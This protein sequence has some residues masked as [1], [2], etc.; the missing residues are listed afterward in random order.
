MQL[1]EPVRT[2]LIADDH[3]LVRAGLVAAV[4]HALAPERL[5]EAEDFPETLEQATT[6]E[7]L[8]LIVL[9]LRMPGAQGLS[10]LMMLK[11]MRPEAPVLVCSGVAEKRVIAAASAVGA[12][13]FVSKSAS[14]DEIEATLI[15]VMNGEAPGLPAPE[16]SAE[17]KDFA[18]R[19]RELSPQQFRVMS[20][21]GDGLLNKQIAHEMGLSVSTVKGHV[22]ELLRKLN[23]PRR[24]MLIAALRD[25]SLDE[26]EFQL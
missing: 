2:V 6:A 20:L 8:D 16:A 25:F 11:A 18:A 23:I 4:A 19:I 3:P 13:G 15:A 17:T 22:T 12:S 9:D 24:T 7:D 26:D 14:P 1:D 5:L 21:I 10:G